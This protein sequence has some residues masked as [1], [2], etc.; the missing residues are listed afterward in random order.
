[1]RSLGSRAALLTLL[2]MSTWLPSNV[3]SE[4]S[5]IG[6]LAAPQ[7]EVKDVRFYFHYSSTPAFVAGFGTH[8]LMDTSAAY[9]NPQPFFKPV[10][11]PKIQVDFY[12]SPPL[13]GP[14]TFSG[15]WQVLVWVNGSAL[16]PAGW[17]LQFWERSPRGVVIWDSSV[18]SPEVNGGPT[19][20]P[21]Y[22]DVPI[23]AYTLTARGLTHTFSADNTIEVEVTINTGSTLAARVW[24]DSASY[25]SFASFPSHDYATPAT[26]TTYDANRTQ[27][28]I[29]S[30]YWSETQRKVIVGSR[31]T[32]A[33]GGY[34]IA[35][36]KLTINEPSGRTVV[37]NLPMV[38]VS[39]DTSSYESTYE[40]A[41]SYPANTAL[42]TYTVIVIVTDNTGNIQVKTGNFSI[43]VQIPVSI[44]TLDGHGR[45]LRSAL[46][47]A[48]VAGSIVEEGSTN[49]SGWLD[50]I[51]YTAEYTIK[52]YWQGVQVAAV[53]FQPTA[54]SRLTINCSVYDPVFMI[55]D[56]TREPL[57][58]AWVFLDFPNGS[59]A[60]MPIVTA[61][62]GRIDLL[63]ASAGSYRLVVFWRDVEVANATLLVD[64]DGPFEL[65]TLVFRLEAQSLDYNQRPVEGTYVTSRAENG[66]ILGFEV[67]D[68]RGAALFKLPIGNY[69]LSTYW[70][71]VLVNQTDL[72]VDFDGPLPV[73]CQVYLLNV[74]VHDNRG[75]PLPGAYL[76]TTFTTG[77]TKGFAVTSMSGRAEFTVPLGTYVVEAYYNATYWLTGV[78]THAARTVTVISNTELLLRLEE[79]PPPIYL[80]VAFWLIVAVIVAALALGMLFRRI[81]KRP[82]GPSLVQ[83]TPIAPVSVVP[84]QPT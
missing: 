46:V 37:S 45:A 8:Y 1:M 68:T 34:D 36:T 31:V 48:E 42:G 72:R 11:Q 53:S 43:G 75:E 50:L 58:L 81:T 25:P 13:A 35:T 70:D 9:S 10:G 6:W 28:S 41:W 73:Q 39:G 84:T 12:L 80:T 64:S 27:R 55:L 23:F 3:T 30:T 17:N 38:R 57:E 47:V 24:Y 2:L 33:F 83:P 26:V 54:P 32:D 7:A 60:P 66:L 59:Q 69:T 56:H 29:F 62:D 19:G 16:H 20:N 44:E 74:T 52:V 77:R 21:G 49:A 15:D 22:V 4:P 51:L 61:T 82:A 67:T 76:V 63:Q 71:G 5:P 78:S 14:A 18:I 40:A 65:Q 79:Y